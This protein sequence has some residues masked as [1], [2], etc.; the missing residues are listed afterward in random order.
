M[1]GPA[2]TMGTVGTVGTVVAPHP[3][4]RAS[5][6]PPDERRQMVVDATLS[7]LLQNGEMVT[8]RQIADAAGIAEGTIF[9]VFEDKDALIDAVLDR[10]LDREPLERA[11]RTIDPGQPLE[12][13]L[14]AA[15]VTLQ[16]RVVDFWRLLTSIG[17]R[18]HDRH[19][20]PQEVSAALV[21]LLTAYRDQLAVE[22]LAAARMLGALTLSVTHP[23]LVDE[24]MSPPE[25]VRLFLYGTHA[26]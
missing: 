19:R 20:P 3:G 2:G 21:E 22:P 12:R 11:L 9:R 5:A 4:K 8:T 7:L 14:E 17:T 25:L 16:Q 15:V 26:P 1:R 6:L 24:P 18:F 10:A 13:S 23:V